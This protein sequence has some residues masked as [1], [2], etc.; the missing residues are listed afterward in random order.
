LTFIHDVV[1]PKSLG[2][3]RLLHQY[4]HGQAVLPDW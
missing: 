4:V 1:N 2:F 3:K